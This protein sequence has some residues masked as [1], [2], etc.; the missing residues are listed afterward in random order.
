MAAV[1]LATTASAD[2]CAHVPSVYTSFGCPDSSWGWE[3]DGRIAVGVEHGVVVSKALWRWSRAGFPEALP[4]FTWPLIPS[5]S[6]LSH[7]TRGREVL[8]PYPTCSPPASRPVFLTPD[9]TLAS[10]PANLYL[11][12][13]DEVRGRTALGV[14]RPP[15]PVCVIIFVKIVL[16]VV[17][18]QPPAPSLESSL[19]VFQACLHLTW[20]LR[21]L[22]PLFPTSVVR[23]SQRRLG[24]S[25]PPKALVH[26][27][28][29][30]GLLSRKLEPRVLGKGTMHDLP[31]SALHQAEG[32][33]F[34]DVLPPPTQ[35]AKWPPVS[36]PPPA[37]R[38]PP[39]PALSV[40]P[41][42]VP[43]AVTALA[44]APLTLCSNNGV[45]PNPVRCASLGF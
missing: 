29:E 35:C 4:G 33:V 10:A 27:G 38:A 14:R 39:S 34:P 16:S 6:A 9:Q 24:L 18:P 11:P 1:T 30:R 25:S 41:S 42:S 36:P 8:Q 19:S 31:W 17:L 23:P 37:V 20:L 21:G 12:P 15:S 44:K 28:K 26:G 32:P 45:P 7:F 13:R 22:C 43:S 40:R 3:S 2:I 5:R